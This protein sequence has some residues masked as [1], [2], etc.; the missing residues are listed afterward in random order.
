MNPEYSALG[1]DRDVS[2]CKDVD[3]NHLGSCGLTGTLPVVHEVSSKG[4]LSRS[5][6][7]RE[8]K[9]GGIGTGSVLAPE[10]KEYGEDASSYYMQIARLARKRLK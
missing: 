7:V 9:N 1:A 8:S 2:G 10:P 5:E 4:P 6:C 3:I